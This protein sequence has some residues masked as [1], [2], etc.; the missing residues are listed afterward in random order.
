MNLAQKN[1]GRGGYSTRSGGPL[2]KLQKRPLMWTW[3]ARLLAIEGWALSL[4]GLPREGS[5]SPCWGPTAPAGEEEQPGHVSALIHD[6][7]AWLGA[8]RCSMLPS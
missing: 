4:P 5:C 2:W 8:G 1:E 7:Q 6:P 3:P